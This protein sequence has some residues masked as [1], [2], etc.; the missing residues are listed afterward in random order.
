MASPAFRHSSQPPI[1]SFP[2]SRN[3][4]R[5]SNLS[6]LVDPINTIVQFIVHTRTSDQSWRLITFTFSIE[7]PN[8]S[9]FGELHVT[10]TV[11]DV[12]IN[13]SGEG[14][15]TLH[16]LPGET[17]TFILQSLRD[18]ESLTSPSLELVTSSE[19]SFH[20]ARRATTEELF[21]TLDHYDSLVNEYE[22]AEQW[23]A[24]N[25]YWFNEDFWESHEARS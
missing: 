24:E 16:R 2:L 21:D 15:I 18:T 7:I 5:V 12:T 11:N 8:L 9:N 22:I 23:E 4:I 20:T 13:L 1:S 19:G 3:P 14:Q 6:V 10:Y 25:T 17:S